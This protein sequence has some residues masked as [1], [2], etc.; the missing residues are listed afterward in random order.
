[1]KR[2]AFFFSIICLVNLGFAEEPDRGRLADGR[3]FRK[4]A[5]GNQL[6]DYIAELELS[7]EALNRTVSS[8]E[9]DISERDRAIAGLSKCAQQENQAAIKE[10]DLI[11]PSNPTEDNNQL[12]DAIAACETKLKEVVTEF[13]ANKIRIATGCRSLE[14]Q[15]A[16]KEATIASIKQSMDEKDLALT[17]ARAELV[18]YK[19]EKSVALAKQPEMNNRKVEVAIDRSSRKDLS[20][21]AAISKTPMPVVP[22]AIEAENE[23]S[24]LAIAKLG[25]QARYALKINSMNTKPSSS[26]DQKRSRVVDSLRGTVL[27]ELNKLNA[28]AM[29][30]DQ[31]FSR[32]SKVKHAVEF[33]LSPLVSK[34]GNSVAKIRENINNARSVHELSQAKAELSQLKS[35]LQA[36]ISL[37]QRMEKLGA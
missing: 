14:E 35:T 16:A 18:R 4:D 20:S 10:R 23:D 28:I 21:S 37:M 31:L 34:K 5:E 30:R 36:D 32:Y 8:L 3:A 9:D 11:N 1:M 7:V 15:L 24:A 25:E 12:Y 13:E 26:I 27:T 17:A 19:A 2:L 29:E 33:K 22:A 6:V